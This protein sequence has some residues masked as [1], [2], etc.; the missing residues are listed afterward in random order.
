M[1][2]KMTMQTQLVLRLLLVDPAREW[3]GLELG[4][5]SG[6]PSGTYHPILGRLKTAGWLESR[7][8]EVDAHAEKRPR[9]RYY[10]LTRDG[11]DGAR[12]ALA[13]A[14]TSKSSPRLLAHP[15]LGLSEPGRGAAT[16][17]P[18]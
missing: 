5:E 9:R 2:L 16:L 15:Q 14:S 13:K 11:I 4:Q 7:W 1:P 6:L 18:G 3:Y 17:D 10:R 12:A 8:E